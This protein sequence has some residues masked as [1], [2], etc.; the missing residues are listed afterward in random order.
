VTQAL[1]RSD[2]S[3]ASDEIGEAARAHM[4]RRFVDPMVAEL[5]DRGVEDP[6]L[7]AEITAAALLGINLARALGWFDE[8]RSVPREQLVHLVTE[9]LDQG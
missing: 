8:I 9:L 1:I 3:D 2:A 7:R 4:A 6:H 5:S